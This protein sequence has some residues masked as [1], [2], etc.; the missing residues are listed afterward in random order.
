MNWIKAES[1]Q[2]TDALKIF[3][4]FLFIIT[5]DGVCMQMCVDMLRDQMRASDPL[6]SQYLQVVA[7]Y[8]S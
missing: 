7:S 2:R 6:E 4:L 1:S 5:C 3:I 8:L